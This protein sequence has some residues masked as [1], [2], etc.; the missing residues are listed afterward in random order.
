MDGLLTLSVS[1][2][3]LCQLRPYTRSTVHCRTNADDVSELIT[4]QAWCITGYWEWSV[5]SSTWQSVC[6]K[7]KVV[8]HQR[9]VAARH[10]TSQSPE[11]DCEIQHG[12]DRLASSSL[13]FPSWY[14]H[15]QYFP[16]ARYPDSHYLCVE[17][18]VHS[19]TSAFPLTSLFCDILS[20]YIA[21]CLPNARYVDS[22]CWY[23]SIPTHCQTIAFTLL[24]CQPTAYPLPGICVLIASMS[25]Y[26]SDI[27]IPHC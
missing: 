1:C 24:V 25:A 7:V 15:F 11:G 22:H 27:G 12:L 19:Q 5:V 4:I 3:Q 18:P 26:L 8:C 16:I 23:V 6:V 10:W 17:F 20:A 21:V 9:Q 14:L 2:G 13:P